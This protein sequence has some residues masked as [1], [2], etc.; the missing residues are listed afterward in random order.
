MRAAAVLLVIV[1]HIRYA[2]NTSG[3]LSALARSLALGGWV[4]VDL[5]LV[6]SGFLISGLL[7]SEQRQTGS[8]SFRRF[9]IRRAFKILP[10][11]YF[12]CGVAVILKVEPDPQK[13]LN[14][15]FFVQ[16]YFQ[17]M[18]LHTWSL[19]LEE[20]F[21]LLLP[22]LLIFLAHGRGE[23]GF[24]KIP[25]IFLF[26][27][28]ACLTMRILSFNGPPSG[29]VPS[30]SATHLRMD[31]LFFG[32]LISYFHHYE[33]ATFQR[34]AV[35]GGHWLLFGGT[36]FLLPAFLMPIGT[37]FILT[38]GLSFFYIGAGMILIWLIAHERLFRG[39]FWSLPVF[40]GACSYSVYLW[41]V[42]TLRWCSQVIPRSPNPCLYVVSCVAS[43]VGMG[44][45]M[46][47]FI[48]RP[49]LKLRRLYDKKAFHLS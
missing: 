39:A 47:L 4:G 7:F 37:F 16:N 35:E 34:V 20:H 33:K 38:F 29:A 41:H 8:I 13:V 2:P 12:L 27:A 17:G 24:K 23:G 36:L 6:L 40:V 46:W 43:T 11:F 42:I 19:A 10:P 32:V 26:T 48:E 31:S 18:W 28:A 5:F 1:R 21:Y 15:L 30:L 22:W 44:A 25:E 9:F 14:D 45:L 3:V 49:A